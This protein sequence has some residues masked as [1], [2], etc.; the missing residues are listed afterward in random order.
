[1]SKF[2]FV[3]VI[4]AILLSTTTPFTNAFPLVGGYT[5]IWS[6]ATC[7]SSHIGCQ[8]FGSRCGA[9][10]WIGSSVSP[11][12]LPYGVIAPEHTTVL[13]APQSHCL[14]GRYACFGRI[15]KPFYRVNRV[16]T[17]LPVAVHQPENIVV[18]NNN[19]V[20]IVP[21]RQPLEQATVLMTVTETTP[22]TVIESV[23]E[24]VMTP[25]TVIESV[26]ERVVDTQTLPA[27]TVVMNNFVTV[28]QQETMP[29]IVMATPSPVPY[30]VEIEAHVPVA[31][32]CQEAACVET[33]V[34]ASEGAVC[35]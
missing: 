14:L 23:T 9:A 2:F 33:P 24:R 35:A 1:M 11:H 32:P 15:V 6:C 28:T 13:E 7:V 12:G 20:D 31:A 16:S 29:V 27:Q 22:T 8:V 34:C 19:E 30:T 10:P 26:T 4:T 18:N 5:R 17:Y 21:P 25:T 3:L